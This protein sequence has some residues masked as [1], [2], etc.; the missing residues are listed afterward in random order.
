MSS[1]TLFICLH[2][3]AKQIIKVHSHM[4]FLF[5]LNQWNWTRTSICSMGMKMTFSFELSW[6]FWTHW[7]ISVLVLIINSLHFDLFHRKQVHILCHFV[8]VINASWFKKTVVLENK[9]E[10]VRDSVTCAVWSEGT[11]RYMYMF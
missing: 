4:S 3:E 10:I 2:C 7:Q 6:F 1:N 5:C 11:V 8:S 9:T